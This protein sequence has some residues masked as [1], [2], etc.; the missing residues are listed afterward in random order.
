MRKVC[1]TH[2][3]AARELLEYGVVREGAET[4]VD[5]RSCAADC[6]CEDWQNCDLTVQQ[7]WRAAADA[8]LPE[9]R[10]REKDEAKEGDHPA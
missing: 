8:G 6:G 7:V 4:L 10:P 5:L 2:L 1:V 3:D 9:A